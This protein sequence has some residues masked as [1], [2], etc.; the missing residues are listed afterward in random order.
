MRLGIP[1]QTRVALSLNRLCTGNSLRGC[2]EIYGIHESSASIIERYL[3]PLV[4]EK[5]LQLP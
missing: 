1:L 4:I 2:V 3:K 5:K